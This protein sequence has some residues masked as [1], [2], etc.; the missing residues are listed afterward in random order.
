MA[1]KTDPL[2]TL[3]DKSGVLY[4]RLYQRMRALILEGS[5]PS[6]MRLPSSRRLGADLGIARNTASLAVEQ[7]LADAWVEPRRPQRGFCQRRAAR[8]RTRR[9][10]ER[11]PGAAAHWQPAGPVRACARRRRRLPDRP[12]GQAAGKG[13]GPGRPQ[14]ALRDRQHGRRR[15]SASI[16]D[17]VAPARGL[18][19][20]ADDVLVVTSTQAALDLMAATLP[21]GSAVVVEDPGYIFAD[22]A[23]TGRGHR[24]V[25]APVDG[26]G[27]DIAAARRAEPRPALILTTPCC[28]FP[29]GRPMSGERR[30][31]LLDWAAEVGA[32]VVDDEFDANFR[33]D[34]R[35]PSLPLRCEGSP[36][37]VITIASFNRLA[38]NSLRLG[39][40]I[41]PP[42][43]HEPLLRARQAVD[44]FVNLRNQLVLRAFIEEGGYAAHLR[45]CRELHQ[46]R[47]DAL[48][49]LLR[50]IA[51]RS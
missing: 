8:H 28:H 19:V 7:L 14:P 45:R 20:A 47:R 38:F 11:G 24:I 46:T 17:L 12:L 16:A 41:E 32:W 13:V 5:W 33:F 21:P 31:A 26:D 15:A 51:E 3:P 22:S 30:A 48:L 9:G 39:F 25:P 44:Q 50:S 23:F 35:Q 2:L 4:V 29:T 36:D 6:G 40:M 43:L 49:A 10:A 42:A 37:R 27:L 1:R 34:G 18:T